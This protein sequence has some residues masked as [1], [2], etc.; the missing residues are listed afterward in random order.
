MQ[1]IKTNFQQIQ[2]VTHNDLDGVC[3]YLAL[4]W[5]YGYKLNVISTTPKHLETD[6]NN[7]YKNKEAW[8]KIYFLDLDVTK[9]GELIDDEDTIIIDHH[10][11]NIY[12]FKQATTHIYNE[13]SCSKLIYNNFIKKTNKQLTIA[14]KTLLG[15]ADDLNANKR[16]LPLSTE[17]NIVYH[18]MSNKFNSFVEDYYN[19]F[20]PFDKFK[21]N[22]IALYKKHCSDYIKHLIPFVG[23]IDFEEAKN[24]KVVAVFCDKFIQESCDMLL[25]TH[26]ADIAIAV[27]LDQK[28]IAVRRSPNNSILDVSKFV[29]RIALGGGH[30]FSAGGSLTD[31]FMNFTKLLKPIAKQ[32][33]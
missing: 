14:Q 2:V 13:T 12:R 31:E 30:E 28:R 4:C 25:H 11:T 17:L 16:S 3:S 32:H 21:K 5:L 23:Y 10:K 29:Q 7:L 9:I 18:S 24:I 27:M 8:K 26:Q 6:C 33:N 15:L 19:G 1:E 20:S 22:T